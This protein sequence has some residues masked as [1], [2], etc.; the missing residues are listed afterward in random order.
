MSRDGVVRTQGLR[1][2]RP[3]QRQGLPRRARRLAGRRGPP[4]GGRARA[5]GAAQCVGT[6]AKHGFQTPSPRA[7]VLPA[8]YVVGRDGGPARKAAVYAWLRFRSSAPVQRAFGRGMAALSKLA[9]A[10]DDAGINKRGPSPTRSRP[11][12]GSRAG[13]PRGAA[14]RVRRRRGR[15]GEAPAAVR[16]PPLRAVWPPCHCGASSVRQARRLRLGP[17]PGNRG[18]LRGGD[19]VAEPRT[20]RSPR[21]RRRSRSRTSSWPPS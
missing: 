16:R 4:L 7:K 11:N 8:W 1:A 21:R 19:D 10:L 9:T 15:F 2:L 13:G 20:A 17:R 14:R 5:G 18:D 6:T 12:W 3:R